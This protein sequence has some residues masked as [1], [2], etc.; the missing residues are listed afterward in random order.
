MPM[1]SATAKQPDI[2]VDVAVQDSA[3]HESDDIE[4][5]VRNAVQ[6]AVHYASLP[7]LAQSR[8]LELCII[9]ANNDLVQVLNREY[10]DKDKP[11]NVLTFA[12]LDDQT[13][14]DHGGPLGLGDVFLALETIREEAWAQ[15]KPFDDHLIHLCVHGTLHL[16]GYDHIEEDDANTM[17]T[18]EIRILSQLGI[19]NPYTEPLDMA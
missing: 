8:A 12:A 3:W 7:H 19:Q 18:L 14:P 1:T 15:N 16:L 5:I 10:R 2:I 4:D 17:E 11:T 9:L 6:T 13:A